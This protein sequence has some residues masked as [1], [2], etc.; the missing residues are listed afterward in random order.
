M[1]RSGNWPDGL[2]WIVRRVRP[3]RRHLKK[4]TAYEKETGWKY[5]I[6]CTNI[7]EE[8]IEGVPGSRDAQFIDVLHR[9]HAV[10]EDGVRTGKA[11]GLR[12]LPSKSWKVNCGWV[13]AAN[14]AADL[15]A[16]CR[17]LGPARHRRPQRRRTGY[18]PLPIVACPCPARPPRPPPHPENQPQLAV[19]ESVR[20]LLAAHLRPARTRMNSTNNPSDAEGGHPGAVGAGRTRAHRATRA[21]TRKRETDMKIKNRHQHD[22]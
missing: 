22:Q 4:L 2:R 18:A 14:I 10:V 7:P 9:Q 19:E 5:S 6:I 17:L 1:S 21:P 12:N 8:G 13:A 16:W 3:S 11:A 15:Q 20:H